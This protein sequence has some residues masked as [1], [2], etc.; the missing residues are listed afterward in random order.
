M[1]LFQILSLLCLVAISTSALPVPDT[2]DNETVDR[3]AACAQ[4]LKG[5]GKDESLAICI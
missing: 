2:D 3:M 1:K 5:V 4:A